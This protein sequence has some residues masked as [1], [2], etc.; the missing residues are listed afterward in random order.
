MPLWRYG[1]RGGAK[2]AADFLTGKLLLA[3]NTINLSRVANN[4]GHFPG[5]LQGGFSLALR[6]CM[7]TLHSSAISFLFLSLCMCLCSQ[8]LGGVSAVTCNCCLQDDSGR[9]RTSLG[10]YETADRRSLSCRRV[11]F[12]TCAIILMGLI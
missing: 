9:F 10:S 12:K 11:S 4:Q 2:H 8:E 5:N 3:I 1:G 6:V 7:L